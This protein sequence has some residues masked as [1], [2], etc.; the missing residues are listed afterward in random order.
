M[1]HFSQ[2]TWAYY[3]VNPQIVIDNLLLPWYF[4]CDEL[5]GTWH[6]LSPNNRNDKTTHLKLFSPAV[7]TRFLFFLWHL[8]K[9][10]IFVFRKIRISQDHCSHS[11]LSPNFDRA[12]SG[13][14]LHY[15]AGFTANSPD[16]RKVIWRH[17]TPTLRFDR[18]Y[19]HGP[20]R[21]IVCRA[22]ASQV[23]RYCHSVVAAASATL[24]K[25]HILWN[26][27]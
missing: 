12:L 3:G 25:G 16:L 22:C 23:G 1:G 9:H 10:R 13:P 17:Q 11:K 7:T 18:S 14:V 21:C 15:S 24:G 6:H 4:V 20:A 2:P 19:G 5:F 8:R 27:N 26:N